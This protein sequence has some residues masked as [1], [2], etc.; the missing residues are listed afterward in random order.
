[1]KKFLLSALFFLAILPLFAQTG[2]WSGKLD[3][4]GTSITI[5][6][7]LGESE[8][9]MDSPDQGALGIP[10]ELQR[11][12]TGIKI[13]IPSIGAAYEGL[14]FGRTISGSFTQRGMSF[15]LALSPGAPKRMRPQTP[16]GPFPYG[17]EEVAFSNGDALLKGTLTLP[18]NF[19]ADTPVLIMVTGSGLQNRD[20]EIFE[21]KPFAVIADALARQGIASLRY[22]DRGFGESTG[23]LVNVTTEELKNDALAGIELLRARFS[24]VGVLGHS[25]GGTIALMLAAEKKVDFALSL[26]GMFVSGEK[27]LLEQNRH[28]LLQ[29]A[30]SEEIT[31]RY[32]KTLKE[33]FDGM[34]AGHV[35]DIQ[36]RGLPA[37]LE[38]NL[39]LVAQSNT[40]YMRCFLAL[41]LSDSLPKVEC[42]VL[43]LNGTKDSQVDCEEN[44]GVL[45]ERLSCPKKIIAVDGVNHLFQHCN[46]GEVS[47]Y[48]DIEQTMAPE[49]LAML[50]DWL[51]TL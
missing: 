28:A 29:A 22:D 50:T 9:T 16:V 4:Y 13:S 40:P 2:D 15:P 31:E 43:A 26:A 39:K 46:T 25:E 7:H 18:E 23:D 1:M 51:K 35:P 32:C 45:R 5:V 49:V 12:A 48:K 37:E 41:D 19:G 27:L 38:K 11:T 34:K 20:E 47:E 10:A 14:F 8:C 30:Y 42:P 36:E 3:V 44:L 6:F 33:V 24:R 21:H 17:T